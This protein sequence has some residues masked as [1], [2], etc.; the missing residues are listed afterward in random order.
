MF[1][2]CGGELA[3]TTAGGAGIVPI[4]GDNGDGV[5]LTIVSVVVCCVG[6]VTGGII[7]VVRLVIELV[8][9]LERVVVVDN[10]ICTKRGN[11]R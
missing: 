2:R 3:S 1:D 7:G 8:I 5:V 4:G 11:I 9:G 6:F 10:N